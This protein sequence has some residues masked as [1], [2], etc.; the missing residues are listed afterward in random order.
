MFV[1]FGYVAIALNLENAST[2]KTVTLS[3]L[4]KLENSEQKQ[5]RIHRIA[6]ENLD[7]LLRVIRYNI[8]EYIH[9]YRF[10][11]KLFPFATYPLEFEWNYADIFATELAAIGELI[12]K[13]GMRVSAHPDHFTVI[14]SPDEKVFADSAKDLEYH[15]NILTAMGLNED[16]KLVIHLGGF[17]GDKKESTNRFLRNFHR[18][19]SRV[20]TRL[21]LENDDKIYSAEE[22]LKVCQEL[23]L[24]M[25]LDIHHHACNPSRRLAELLPAIWATWP[26][27]IPKIHVSSPKDGQHSRH[28][29]D[30][31]DA[32]PIIEF[33]N[34]AQHLDRDFDIMVE[35]KMKDR[36]MFKLISDV[37]KY[38]GIEL[39]DPTTATQYRPIPQP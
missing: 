26:K 33:F 14:N 17:Y 20:Q 15:D 34:I 3:N 12:K 39:F 16:Y 8:G 9:V 37:S 35:A 4:H 6:R 22:V 19:P 27:G 21:M 31:V 25:V 32:P 11:S 10:T 7:N 5:L 2:S 13:S 30:Y 36:A 24:P 23:Q 1:R 18:L 29:A 38:P 28:H